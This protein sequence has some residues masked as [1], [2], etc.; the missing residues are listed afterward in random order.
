MDECE[1]SQWWGFWMDGL[2]EWLDTS[3]SW[4]DV[5]VVRIGK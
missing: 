3:L 1:R 2:T 4:I 5:N